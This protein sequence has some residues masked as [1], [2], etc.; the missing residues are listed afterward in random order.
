YLRAAMGFK[1]LIKNGKTK[2]HKKMK[3]IQFTCSKS[4]SEMTGISDES[5]FCGKCQKCVHDY[6]S[7]L[8]RDPVIIS[9]CGRF[10]LSQIES[11]SRQYLLPSSRAV[12]LSL[13]ALLGLSL[14]YGHVS[15]QSVTNENESVI[16]TSSDEFI[17]NG[18]LIDKETG[19]PLS[20]GTI[21]LYNS[22]KMVGVAIADKKGNFSIKVDT[23]NNEIKELSVVFDRGAQYSDTMA[24]SHEKFEN[25]LVEL[26]VKTNW[27]RQDYLIT[28]DVHSVEDKVHN[29]KLKER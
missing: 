5:K 17:I 21:E 19:S 16:E 9:D 18:R 2:F 1:A 23:V 27:D 25:I 10:N 20:Y 24:I 13:M 6:S 8:T 3:K 12:Q 26:E 7:Q 22:S 11:F 14:S 29:R 4:W 28:G 15:A